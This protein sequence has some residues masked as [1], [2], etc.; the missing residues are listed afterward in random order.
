MTM[1]QFHRE[2]LCLHGLVLAWPAEPMWWVQDPEWSCPL[3][4]GLGGLM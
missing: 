2:Q 4:V 3:G 1:D